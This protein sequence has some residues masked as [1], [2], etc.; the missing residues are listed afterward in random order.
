MTTS[1]I[2]IIALNVSTALTLRACRAFALGRASPGWIRVEG[3]ILQI[4]FDESTVYNPEGD[5]DVVF[6][7]HLTYAYT[8]RG[9]RYRSDRFTYRPTRWLAQRDAY[10]M[11]QGLRKGQAV[12]VYHD[13]QRPERAVVLP[14][15]DGGNLVRL[16]LCAAAVCLSSWWLFAV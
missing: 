12:D 2:P 6:T 3:T 13:P 10:A 9:R 1:L 16:C 15:T 14:G 4:G 11:L 7:A 5:D 8:V